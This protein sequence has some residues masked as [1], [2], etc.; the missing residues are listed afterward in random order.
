[1]GT[2]VL[3]FD[4]PP[5]GGNID[6]SKAAINH[7]LTGRNRRVTGRL[8]VIDYRGCEGLGTDM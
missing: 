3:H 2:D 6:R 5:M 7:S 4:F 8:A 1:M